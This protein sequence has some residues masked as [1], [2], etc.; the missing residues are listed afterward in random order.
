MAERELMR[1][2]VSRCHAATKKYKSNHGGGASS[3]V[4]TEQSQCMDWNVS[5]AQHRFTQ[6]Q[7]SAR[8]AMHTLTDNAEA[9]AMHI[10]TLA[11]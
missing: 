10:C 2:T 5:Q 11:G 7:L 3:V 8:D 6:V 9:T 1:N 4:C